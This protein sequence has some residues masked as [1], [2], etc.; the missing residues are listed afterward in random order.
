[1]PELP[2]KTVS[3]HS[4]GLMSEMARYINTNQLSYQTSG[5]DELNLR[6]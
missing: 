6:F 1:M 5:I 4:K 2:I 3:S